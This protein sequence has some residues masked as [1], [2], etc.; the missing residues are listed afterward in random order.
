MFVALVLRGHVCDGALQCE[1]F[2]MPNGDPAA[3]LEQL[4]RLAQEARETC[5]RAREAIERTR[6]EE[7]RRHADEIKRTVAEEARITAEHARDTAERARD[8]VLEEVRATADTLNAILEQMKVVEQ[9][10]RAYRDVMNT[11]KLDSN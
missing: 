9:M 6:E 7:G 3:E 5:E 11:R 8:V 4:R 2:I 10:R 1:H